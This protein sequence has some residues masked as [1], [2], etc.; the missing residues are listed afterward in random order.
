MVSLFP[1]T[2]R[3]KS[4]AVSSLGYD[5]ARLGLRGREARVEVIRRAA[6]QTA[7]K[8]PD[9]LPDAERNEMLAELATSTYRLL[10]PRKRNRPMERVQL[11][12]GPEIE[13][14]LATVARKPLV[15]A[16]ESAVKASESLV[17]AEL[18]QPCEL[19]VELASKVSKSS[20]AQE[21]N[22]S[23]LRKPN[24]DCRLGLAY[25]SVLASF[26]ASTLLIIWASLAS[27][28]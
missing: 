17:V 14:T 15:A 5:F 12:M 18:V 24:C 19:S 7:A 1:R 20:T 10:D 21:S 26:V 23:A 22:P 6:K 3:K 2:Q 16:L 9:S 27:S 11:S 25:V 28:R 13:P 8:I 4:S